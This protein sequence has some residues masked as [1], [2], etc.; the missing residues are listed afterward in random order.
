MIRSTAC[1]ALPALLL[2]CLLQGCAAPVTASDP[3]PAAAATAPVSMEN[4]VSA[5][6]ASSIG[7]ADSG[8]NQPVV[9]VHH[10]DGILL[11]TGQVT[12]EDEKSRIS[13]AA[14]FA[15]GAGLRRLSNELRVVE[16]I[17]GSRAGADA[18]LASAASALLAE[19]G[20]AP[21]GQITA[22]VENATVYLLGRVA[23]A[24]GDAAAQRVST[25]QGVAGVKVVF[26][27]TD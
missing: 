11:L 26:D 23:R 16:R 21:A 14:A 12:S 3:A 25:L 2:A 5:A 17:D 1:I 18:A 9:K 15:A 19:A 6:V 22:V 8:A 24:Q 7:A 4:R 27:Y 13:N 10:H 20:P